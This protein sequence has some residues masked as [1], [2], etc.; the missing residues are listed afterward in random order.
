MNPAVSNF[1]L[2]WVGGYISLG[3]LTVVSLFVV[4]IGALIVSAKQRAL[5][6]SMPDREDTTIM[7][8]LNTLAHVALIWPLIVLIMLYASIVQGTVSP[9]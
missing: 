1:I 3:C 2:T 7:D 9:P 4:E 6:L 5:I 8:T